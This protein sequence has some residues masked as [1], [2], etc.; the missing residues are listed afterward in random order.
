M[1]HDVCTQK[2][3]DFESILGLSVKITDAHFVSKM[4]LDLIGFYLFTN[5]VKMRPGQP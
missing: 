5:S 2:V 1:R 4:P 3:L